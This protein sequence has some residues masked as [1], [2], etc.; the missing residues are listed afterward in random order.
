M[1]WP[2]NEKDRKVTNQPV[3]PRPTRTAIVGAARR[4]FLQ[5]GFGNV[6]MDDLAKEADVSRRT[7]YN[8]FGS[9]EE[10]LDEMLVHFSAQLGDI[11]PPGIET[12]GDV[13]DVLRKITRSVLAFQDTPE[14]IGLVRMTVADA[15]HFEWIAAAFD[16]LLKP[17]LERFER[18]L[19]HLT[20]LGVLNCPHP[21]LAAHQFLGLVNEPILWQRVLNRETPPFDHDLVIDEAVQMFLLRYRVQAGN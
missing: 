1:Q 11:L 15:R 21:A 7:L 4:L 8:Q 9:K 5:R 19:I 2:L 6:S 18:Y 10:I 3:A 20:S 17:Y 16:G 13:D 14:F 12:E